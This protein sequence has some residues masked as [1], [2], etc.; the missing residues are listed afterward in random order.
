MRQEDRRPT[1]AVRELMP[2]DHAPWLTLWESYNAFYDRKGVTALAPEITQTTWQRFFDP[3]E[4]IHALVAELDGR[5]VGFAH[6]VFR[7]TTLSIPP[8]CYLQDLFTAE[9]ARGCGVA[10]NLIHAVVERARAEGSELLYW[11]TQ[12]TNA[13]A[14]A[15]YDRIAER[16]GFIIYRKRLEPSCGKRLK[17][18]RSGKLDL[19]KEFR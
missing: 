1:L 5:L 16:S 10:T 13:R 9:E 17:L 18:N 12:E 8:A 15:L 14:R 4:P 19:L 3:G 6:L 7:R 11:Q 2:G